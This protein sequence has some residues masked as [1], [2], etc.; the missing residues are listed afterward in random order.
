MVREVVPSVVGGERLVR[1]EREAEFV[2]EARAAF[3]A[4]DDHFFGCPTLAP[5]GGGGAA[6]TSGEFSTVFHAEH[7]A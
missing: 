7:C 1:A 3:G 6:V 5:P 2:I 4:S